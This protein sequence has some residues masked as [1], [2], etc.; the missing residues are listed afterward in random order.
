MSNLQEWGFEINPYNWCVANK[1][2]DRKQMTVVWHVDDL[3]ISHENGDTVDALIKNLS[4]QYGKEA[5][6]TTH[7]G[8]VHEYLGMKL[9]YRKQGKVKIDTTDYLKKIL[10]DLPEKY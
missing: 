8:K 9:D 3:N 2:F 10:D 4:K 6:L 5:D 7:R 1:T